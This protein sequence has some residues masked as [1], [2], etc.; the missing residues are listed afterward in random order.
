MKKSPF[1]AVALLIVLLASAF[2][3][4]SAPQR[5]PR[6]ILVIGFDGMDY[7]LTREMIKRGELPNFSDLEIQGGFVPM[8]TC[9]PP[10][11]PVVWSTM[12]IGAGAGVHGISDFIKRDPDTYIPSF[13][14]AKIEPPKI[15][16]VAGITLPSGGIDIQLLQKGVPFW[17]FLGDAHIRSVIVRMPVTFPAVYAGPSVA[18]LSGMGTPDFRGD[19]GS[20]TYFTTETTATEST[21]TG[22]MIKPFR[23]Q[24]GSAELAISGPRDGTDPSSPD[25]L[26]TFTIHADR[27]HDAALI[28]IGDQRLLLNKG[29]WSEW[30]TIDFSFSSMTKVSGI[31]RFYLKNV[32]PELQLYASPVNIDPA[33]PILPI[34][35]PPD[36]CV[37]LSSQLGRFYTQSM[38]EDT[39]A[40]DAGVISDQAYYDQGMIVW[41]ESVSML[42]LMMNHFE[43]G[44]KFFYFSTTDQLSHG[45]WRQFDPESPVRDKEFDKQ[46]PRVVEELYRKADK[47]I[48]SVRQVLNR[49]DDVLIVVSDHGFCSFKKEFELN[50][51]LQH[52]GFLTLYTRTTTGPA[53]LQDINWG[54][55]QAYCVGLN[56]LY[57]N[58][59]GREAHGIVKREDATSVAKEIIRR[60]KE[61]RDPETGEHPV[62]QV[63]LT[64]DIYPGPEQP[65]LSDMIVLLKPPYRISWESGMGKVETGPLIVP[66]KQKWAGEHCD[67]P[68]YVSGVFFCSRPVMRQEATPV[69][70]APTILQ[71]YQMPVPD[72]MTGAPLVQE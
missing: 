13:S 10:Q 49:P 4:L 59:K 38:P 37:G 46:H 44:F 70:V 20:F 62:S 60:L 26:S 66:N 39:K 69:D 27:E 36:M 57:L 64:Q 18:I 68:K 56:S 5:K 48:G 2:P 25:L 42:N 51:W 33:R 23:L 35:V 52:E 55:T 1:A 9:I 41:N 71:L 11:S 12:S 14:L 17:K 61:F 63:C 54:R 67:D 50:G 53:E 15:N 72:Q 65:N 28:Q 24:N 7:S 47:V 32:H 40:A 58:I 31:I 3:A 29:E 22:G 8:K 16:R 21:V 19:Y 45:F 43:E 34:S 30:A 6:R